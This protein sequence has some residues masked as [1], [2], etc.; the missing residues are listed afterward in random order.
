MKSVANFS[1]SSRT[2]ITRDAA[3]VGNAL[4]T[5]SMRIRGRQILPPYTVMYMLCA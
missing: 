1:K 5:I 4:K 3:S 2:E